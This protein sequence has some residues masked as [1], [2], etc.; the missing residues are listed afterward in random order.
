[1]TVDTPDINVAGVSVFKTRVRYTQNAIAPHITGYVDSAGNG[2]AGIEKAFDDVLKNIRAVRP[3]HM[4]LMQKDGHSL[5][6]PLQLSQRAIRTAA[7]C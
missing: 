1:M 7:L 3:K 5:V 2:V 4:L 6:Y